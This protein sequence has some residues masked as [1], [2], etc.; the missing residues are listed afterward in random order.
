M[1]ILLRSFSKSYEE[2]FSKSIFENRLGS[3]YFFRFDA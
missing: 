3:F 1:F 2:S